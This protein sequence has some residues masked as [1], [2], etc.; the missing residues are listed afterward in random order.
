MSSLYLLSL[1]YFDR[2][3]LIGLWRSGWDFLDL[4]IWYSIVLDDPI[5]FIV[6]EIFLLFGIEANNSHEKDEAGDNCDSEGDEG[7]GNLAALI[8][9]VFAREWGVCGCVVAWALVDG[10]HDCGEDT[11]KESLN[12][13]EEEDSIWPVWEISEF[14]LNLIEENLKNSSATSKH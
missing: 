4:F 6:I 2:L 14:N 13:E 12:S 9:D 3:W 7:G 11:S 10:S 1:R 8:V 5:G